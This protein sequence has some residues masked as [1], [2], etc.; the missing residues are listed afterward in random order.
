M[1][2][3]ASQTLENST[4]LSL[5]KASASETLSP[6][7]YQ[8]ENG[9]QELEKY[10]VLLLGLQ[11]LLLWERHLLVEII[12]S[13]RHS[14]VFSKLAFTSIEMIVRDV[15]SITNRVLK[16]ISRRE[17]SSA[18][19]VFSALKHVI[20]LQPDLD[21]A[22]DQNQRQQLILVLNKLKQTVISW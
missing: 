18:L 10:L 5:K 12:P 2:M 7:E 9:D 22:C 11:R 14:E 6:N 8:N 4:G 17:W 15:E 3:K 13:S 19:S 21:K 16:N 20:L 1:L